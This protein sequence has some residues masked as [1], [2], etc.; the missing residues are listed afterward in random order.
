MASVNEFRDEFAA[1]STAS[2]G[3]STEEHTEDVHVNVSKQ[4]LVPASVTSP[5]LLGGCKPVMHETWPT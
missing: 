1:P 2:F 4:F 5:D 3:G